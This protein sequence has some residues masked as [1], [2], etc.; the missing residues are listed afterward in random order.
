M[1]LIGK[2]SLPR[3]FVRMSPIAMCPDKNPQSDNADALE[4]FFWWAILDSSRHQPDAVARLRQ[5]NRQT[6]N[7][8][9]S[10]YNPKT[11]VFVRVW[12]LGARAF[13]EGAVH[14]VRDPQ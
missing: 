11:R 10:S 7:W 8:L 4:E 2:L 1:N 14:V 9:E 13:F 6:P 12:M 5:Q 3:Y